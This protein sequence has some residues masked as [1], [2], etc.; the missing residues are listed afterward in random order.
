MTDGEFQHVVRLLEETPESIRRLIAALPDR[1]LRWKPTADEFSPVEQV[2]HLRDLEREGYGARIRKM[3]AE[4]EPLLPDFDGGRIARER[5]YNSQ[6]F[7][8]AFREFARER[9][10]NVRRAKTLSPAELKRGGVLEGVGPITLGKLF[11][12]MLEHDRSHLKELSDLSERI[13]DNNLQAS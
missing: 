4:N 9:A 11:P 6:D 7:E 13:P 1:Y 3:L 8:P 2:C 5:D 12:L 10:D